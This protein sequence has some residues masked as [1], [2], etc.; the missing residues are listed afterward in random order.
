M[1][2]YPAFNTTPKDNPTSVHALLKCLNIIHIRLTIFHHV[3]DTIDT[4]K[5]DE[6]H[7]L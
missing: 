2:T 3:L 1:S 7:L 5:Y 6:K 4:Y